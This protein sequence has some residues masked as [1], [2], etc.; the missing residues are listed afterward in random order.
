MVHRVVHALVSIMTKHASER[1]NQAGQCRIYCKE[2]A[3]EGNAPGLAEVP[4]CP[5]VDLAQKLREDEL[6]QLCHTLIS[7]HAN[8]RLSTETHVLGKWS[9]LDSDGFRLE[10]CHSGYRCVPS[11]HFTHHF[12]VARPFKK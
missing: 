1:S 5:V 2:A 10:F 6:V 3:G 7:K 4:P 11:S 12:G 8:T 9:E